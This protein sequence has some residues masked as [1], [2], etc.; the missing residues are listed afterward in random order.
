MGAAADVVAMIVAA[1]A[2]ATTSLGMRD[3]PTSELVWAKVGNA[4]TALSSSFRAEDLAPPE[5]EVRL[6]KSRQMIIKGGVLRLP[7]GFRTVNGR[8]DLLV[9]FHGSPDVLGPAM[10]SLDM[11]AALLTVNLGIGSAAYEWPYIYEGALPAMIANVEAAVRGTKL[12]EAPVVQRVA[13]SSWSAGYGAVYRIIAQPTAAAR[14][15]A[16]LLEDSLHAAYKTR[17]T[18]EIDDVKM[19]PF[20]EF[21]A[22]A[23]AGKKLFVMTHSAVPTDGF[24]STSETAVYLTDALGL[25]AQRVDAVRGKGMHEVARAERGNFAM[26]AFTGHNEAAHCDHLLQVGETLLGRLATRWRKPGP[27]P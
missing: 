20:V 1:F 14:V 6:G 24:A 22:A 15:D 16:I 23:M 13:L 4:A 2:S 25:E 5:P 26:A 27:R 8:F 19:G 9:H 7:R 17:K 21:A 3:A 10:E 18:R 12:A 11:G